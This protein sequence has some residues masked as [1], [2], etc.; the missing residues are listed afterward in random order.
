MPST[1]GPSVGLG[2]LDSIAIRRIESFDAR[3][4]KGGGVSYIDPEERRN[5]VRLSRNDSIDE[6]ESAAHLTRLQRDQS[7]REHDSENSE[8][9]D[10]PR[11]SKRGRSPI[12]CASATTAALDED[13]FGLGADVG[14]TASLS[15]LFA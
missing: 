6:V 4:E 14:P 15:D 8:N 3:D 5:L 10:S 12:A 13:I 2:D 9:E 7:N 1:E 11:L